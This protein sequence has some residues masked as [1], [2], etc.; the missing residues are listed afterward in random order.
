MPGSTRS[1]EMAKRLVQQGH[2]VTIV[3][4]SRLSN[5]GNRYFE[6]IEDG[7]YVQW[8]SVPYSNSMGFFK[9][10]Y[11]FLKFS[12]LSAIRASLLDCDLILA[13]STPLTI[14]IPAVFAAK[15]RKVPFVFEV[16]DLWPELPI[17]L[18]ILTNKFFI[19]IAK[20]L[21]IW[22][23]QNSN[24]IIALSPGMKNGILP[25]G[26]P[27]SR[28]GVIP[29][30]CDI[31]DFNLNSIFSIPF[32]DQR[33]LLLD[34]PLI[35]YA[36]TFGR[37]NGVGYFVDLAIELKSINSDV[38]IL[39]IGSGAEFQHIVNISRDA[40]ILGVNLFIE[41]QLPKNA[42]PGIFSKSTM[43]SSVFLDIPE[44]RIN[45]ANKFFDGL[46][47]GKPLFLN[48]GGWMNDLVRS[49]NCGLSGWQQ[50]SSDVA[51]ELHERLHDAQW[52][53]HASHRSLSLAKRYFDRD[54][55]ALQLEQILVSVVNGEPEMTSTIAPGK[56]D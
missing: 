6:T 50:S 8:I 12:F 31:N 47:A 25:T 36:G 30:S 45:S 41:P 14:A 49:H 10:L 23:Y 38:R 5:Q 35:V 7:I 16:R 27:P 32:F 15:Y 24:A 1:F 22:A 26:Y 40:G 51:I 34:G 9:R 20:L 4:S 2:Q 52:L 18:G 42:I 33:P 54:I 44:M 43:I 13:T 19:K 29:N 17:A 53:S 39:L 55:L 56:Y 37:L 46:A 28:I 48:Y 3:T 11:A 21:E